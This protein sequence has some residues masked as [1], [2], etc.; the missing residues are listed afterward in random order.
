MSGFVIR[1]AQPDDVPAIAEIHERGWQ[2]A[3]GH[4]IGH[5]ALEAKSAD[6][7]IAFWRER[8]ADPTRMVL[9][10]TTPDNALM[11][12][13]YGG[14][15]LPHDLTSG[16]IDEFDCELYILH[17]RQEVQGKGLGRQLTAALARHFQ[18][19]GATSL[20]LWAFTANDFRSFYDRLGGEIIAEGV[21]E[22]H[23][24]VAYGWRDINKL[25]A[26]C[27]GASGP[28]QTVGSV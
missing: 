28:H 4:F 25:I 1:R 6:K 14:P 21:D 17:C 18:G 3:Y 26:A 27:E 12:I 23:A 8:I 15:V 5:E 11:G 2:L 9:V 10:G 24:D 22:G 19:Q 7:R 13:V 16:R 20:L